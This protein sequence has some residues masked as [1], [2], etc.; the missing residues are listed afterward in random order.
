VPIPVLAYWVSYIEYLSPPPVE[1]GSLLIPASG[2]RDQS[3][4][5]DTEF[6]KIKVYNWI[7]SVFFNAK[8]S[9]RFIKGEH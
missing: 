2:S 7:I 3:F 6:S 1:L 5:V 9:L 4:G 8:Q